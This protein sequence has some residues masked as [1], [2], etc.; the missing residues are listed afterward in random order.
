ML[1]LV[2]I[3]TVWSLVSRLRQTVTSRV[4]DRVS[5]PPPHASNARCLLVRVG[6]EPPDFRFRCGMCAEGGRRC[7]L[8]SA[9]AFSW[10]LC[11]PGPA[12]TSS[13][14]INRCTRCTIDV[15]DIQYYAIDIHA[16]HYHTVLV[17]AVRAE[18][19]ADIVR[20]GHCAGFLLS[21]VVVVGE[22]TF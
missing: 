11:V 13:S 5:P 14:G 22:L 16:T 4:V 19:G 12:P 2:C 3:A 15:H 7:A 21:E 9:L 20:C 10:R 8:P 6:S 18:A 1:K 17:E